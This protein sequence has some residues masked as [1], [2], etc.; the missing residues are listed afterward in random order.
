MGSIF[1]MAKAGKLLAKRNMAQES[2]EARNQRL[3]EVSKAVERPQPNKRELL[4][5]AATRARLRPSLP[6]AQ[7]QFNQPKKP[8]PMQLE[9]ARRLAIALDRAK[10]K[11]LTRAALGKR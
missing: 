5:A 3:V 6:N 1:E 10:G 4:I 7:T 9:N 2:A 8:S 11:P